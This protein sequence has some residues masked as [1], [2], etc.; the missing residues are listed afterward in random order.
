MTN[1]SRFVWDFPIFNTENSHHRSRS[2]P[3][4]SVKLFIFL[5]VSLLVETPQVISLNQNLKLNSYRIYGD[6]E[7]EQKDSHRLK[8]YNEN[9]NKEREGPN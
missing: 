1:L 2:V 4:T 9:Q 5:S 7:I 3:G 8:L 6:L